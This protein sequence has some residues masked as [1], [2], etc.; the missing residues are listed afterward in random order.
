MS[1]IIKNYNIRQDLFDILYF[2]RG[3]T[4]EEIS[5]GMSLSIKRVQELHKLSS[6][7]SMEVVCH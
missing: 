2:T 6:H 5:Q 3:W 7:K 1:K 4:Y